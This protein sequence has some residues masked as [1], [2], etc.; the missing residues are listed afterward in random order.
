MDSELKLHD[1]LTG[2]KMRATR[3]KAEQKSRL[4]YSFSAPYPIPEE[5]LPADRA[6]ARACIAAFGKINAYLKDRIVLID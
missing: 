3:V 1:K 5:L 6:S 2:L 4:H